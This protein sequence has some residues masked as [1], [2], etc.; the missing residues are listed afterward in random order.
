[1]RMIG[2][3]IIGDEIMRGRRQDKH[4]ARLIEILKARGMHLDWAQYIGDD[5]ALITGTLRRSFAGPDIVF[6]FGGIGST[7]DD[8]TRQCAADALGRPLVL[9]PDAEAEIRARF[10]AE[11]TPQRM[12]MEIGRAHV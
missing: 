12:R 1:M 3:L 4:M 5:P 8:H 11:T 10:G 2:A 6:S 9:H 7:P